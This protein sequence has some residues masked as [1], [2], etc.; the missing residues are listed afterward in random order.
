MAI[1]SQPARVID[2]TLHNTNRPVEPSA[3]P[4]DENPLLRQ[5]NIITIHLEEYFQVDAFNGLIDKQQWY[6]FEGRLHEN[7][8]R[9][10]DLLAKHNVKATFFVLA[11]NAEREPALIREITDQGHDIATSGVYHRN[12]REM[13]RDEFL[14]DLRRSRDL[15][16]QASGKPV[17]G[18]R[19]P[20]GWL[21]PDQL[22]LFE[23]LAQEGFVYDSSL[24]PIL[25][26]YRKEPWRRFPHPVETENGIIWEMPPSAMRIA[27]IDI[28]LPGGNYFRQLPHR[29]GQRFVKSW[30]QKTDAPF[31]MYFHVWELDKTQP[32]ITAAGPLA[33]LRHYRN[34][35]KPSWVM[36]DYFRTYKFGSIEDYLRIQDPKLFADVEVRRA[37][38]AIRNTATAAVITDFVSIPEAG[39]TA[40][41][42]TPVSIVIPCFNEER[43]LPYLGNTLDHLQ[44]VLQDKYV[45]TFIFVDDGSS[46]DTWPVLEKLF[47][48]RPNYTLVKHDKN[49]GVSA[50]IL[51]GMTAADTEIVCSM[52]CDCTYDP[53]ILRE[54]IPQLT[55]DVDLVTASPYHPEGTVR[56]VPEWRLV[57]SKGASF[58][59]RRIIGGQLHTYTSCCRVYRR[60]VIEQIDVTEDHFLG[61]A[62]LVCRLIQQGS[63]ITEYPAT[64]S[65]RIFGLSKMKTVK[66]IFGHLG[67][68]WR[69][70]RAATRKP[71]SIG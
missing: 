44:E 55:D 69:M 51:T 34:L 48:D 7:T 53:V 36:E 31:H 61:I 49:R 2:P 1:L 65:V 58:L 71:E 10:L 52:D 37:K 47:G 38:N 3:G 56:N 33:R 60:S 15:I 70:S 62:E 23:E 20:S 6:R 64:L 12:I 67:L 39:N 43:G 19:M 57:L 30:L 40:G 26:H 11:W 45:P 18:F 27:G 24:L 63:K 35:G 28:P 32:R 9:T 66:T 13:S 50:A 41:P 4:L 8:H 21:K 29:L 68:L 59:Y 16:E 17:Y 14:F 42:V 46:D 5:A 54:M 22:W 25:H